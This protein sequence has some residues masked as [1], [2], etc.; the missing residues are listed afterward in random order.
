MIR[1]FKIIVFVISSI[2][3]SGYSLPK[4]IKQTKEVINGYTLPPKPDPKINN[5]TLLGVDSNDNG[6]RDDVERWI[7]KRFDNKAER[8][9]ALQIA[10]A[11]QKVVLV[12]DEQSALEAMDETDRALDCRG[13]YFIK[14]TKD[15]N[16][17]RE[18]AIFRK[19]HKIFDSEFKDI[20]FNT[21]DR[22][23]A[24]FSYNRNL[25]GK[26]LGGGGGIL[27]STKDKCDE[28]IDALEL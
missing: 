14:H 2:I 7:V 25:S 3:F 20:Q 12:T 8:S 6:V 13:Y 15:M 5:S 22:I 23:K 9:I 24:Y 10:K 16:T 26:V 4:P 17:Y 21:H 11:L 19:N 27:S 18:A 1:D 28:D